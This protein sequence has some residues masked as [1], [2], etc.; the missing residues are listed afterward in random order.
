MIYKILISKLVYIILLLERSF[1]YHYRGGSM[2]ARVTSPNQVE[3]TI[4]FVWRLSGYFCN[5]DTI[6]RRTLIGP[7]LDYLYSGNLSITS[8]QT[9]CESFSIEDDWSFGKKTFSVIPLSEPFSLTYEGCCWISYDG[10]HINWQITMNI[11]TSQAPNSSPI[12]MMFPISNF[13]KFFQFCKA[14][15]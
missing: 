13:L 11:S 7:S 2:S 3:V 5:Q 15:D 6:N 9:Y 10:Q 1:G 8:A 12:T 14:V 4:S